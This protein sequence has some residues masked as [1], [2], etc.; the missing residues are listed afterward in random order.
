VSGGN[1]L[2]SLNDET[3]VVTRADGDRSISVGRDAL[4]N[5]FVTGDHNAVRLTV[6]VAD[7]RLLAR[8]YPPAAA[9]LSV[10]NPYRGLDSFYETDA[11]FFFGREKLVRRA[12]VS[13]QKLQHGAAPRILAVVGA[14]G[15]GKSSLVRAGLLPELARE[16]MAGLESPRVIVLRPGP[17]P[18]GRLAEVLNRIPGIQE[19]TKSTLRTSPR[20]GRFDTVHR[21]LA[22]IQDADR[23]RFVIVVD[24]FEELFTECLDAEARTVFLQNLAC[25]ASDADRLVSVIL[26]LRNDFAGAVQAPTAFVSAVREGRLM[27]QA[28]DRN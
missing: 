11:A 20:D 28:M 21:L 8:V 1:N 2:Q 14:S 25:A 17:D 6:V 19:T 23:S 7:Q 27:V 15:S 10:E 4:G 26:T 13:F 5:V 22:R 24:Q 12:W 3:P 9:A 16:P 18:L